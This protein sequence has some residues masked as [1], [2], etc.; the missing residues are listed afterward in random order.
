METIRTV[1]RRHGMEGLLHEKPFA[2]VNGSGKHNNW[3]MATDDGLNLFEPGENP[4]SN[5]RFLLFATAVVEA[6][7]RY[8]LLLRSSVANAAN[9][10]RLGANEAPP[11][12]VSVFFGGPLTEIFDNIAKGKS[13]GKTN[14]GEQIKI[15]VSSLPSLPMDVSDRNRTSPFAFTGNK[16][17]FRM[18]GSSQSIAT[19]NTFLNVAVAQVLSEFADKLEKAP[20]KNEAIQAIIKESYSKHGKVVFNGNNYADEWVREAERR[21]LPNVRNAVDALSVLISGEAFTLFERH[22]V[23]TREELESRYHIYLEK[24]AKQINIEAGVTIDM[25]RRYIFPAVSGYAAGMA[26]DAAALAAIGAVSVPQEKRARRISELAGEL[27][28]EIAKLEIVLT[29][30]QET[31]ESF[32]RARSYYEKVLPGM[33]VVRSKAD[34]LEKLVS[35]EAWPFPGYE[36]LLF[37]L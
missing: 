16:F 23:F 36:D 35:K 24:Y 4:E 26:R 21:G 8:A 27:Y 14:S 20:D 12:I 3:S 32:A 33:N 10:H 7:D 9:D 28:D 22:R 15:G 31:G 2:G 11:A 1:A 6:V 13:G 37:K 29:E 18:V 30:A 17:E 34:A 19:A 25:A 5:A